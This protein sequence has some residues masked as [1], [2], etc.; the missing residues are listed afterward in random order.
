MLSDLTFG[1]F[2]TY[3]PKKKIA[4]V[5][6]DLRD[7][8]KLAYDIMLGM[9]TERVSSKEGPTSRWLAVVLKSHL[10]EHSGPLREL[11]GPSKVLIPMPRNAPL[12]TDALW[13]PKLIADALCAEG[14]GASVL[15]CVRRVT[16]VPKSATAG[17]GKRADP[18][19]HYD[20][21][22]IDPPL[23]WPGEVV[24]VDDVVTRGSTFLG[25]ASLVN[26]AHPEMKIACFAMIRTTQAPI[27]REI[28][29]PCVGSITLDG[30]G[31]LN[32][33]P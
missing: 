27:F 32:R 33:Q 23:D 20:S 21:M 30:W 24:L 19:E 5:T 1:S 11:L 8:A 25:A 6:D 15:P 2:L 7:S 17:P 9:K 22:E 13:V 18:H 14:L 16:A 28:G 29:D 10:S 26:D 31:R 4:L 12:A 3:V